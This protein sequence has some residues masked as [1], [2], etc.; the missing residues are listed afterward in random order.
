MERLVS[1]EFWNMGGYGFYVWGSYGAALVAFAWN[2]LSV[3]AGR[4]D[5]LR[6]LSVGDELE[7]R[8]D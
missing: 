7:G 6:R 3:R 1:R 5:A 8:D 4:R 2:I